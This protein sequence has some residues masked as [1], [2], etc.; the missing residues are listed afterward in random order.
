MGRKGGERKGVGKEG[1]QGTKW[2]RE[3]QGE[4]R[5]NARG[6]GKKREVRAK[7]RIDQ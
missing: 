3:D 4:R 5:P 6:D 1:G 7:E 2:R